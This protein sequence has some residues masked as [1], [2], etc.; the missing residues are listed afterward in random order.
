MTDS[1]R[2]GFDRGRR[3]DRSEF[4]MNLI[5]RSGSGLPSGGA[6]GLAG[7][8]ADGKRQLEEAEVG[9]LNEDDLD[10][11]QR[12]LKKKKGPKSSKM[13]ERDFAVKVQKKEKA[14]KAMEE[15]ALSAAVAAGGGASKDVQELV[16]EAAKVSF[17][18]SVKEDKTGTLKAGMF[19]NTH[20]ASVAKKAI[21]DAKAGKG[22]QEL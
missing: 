9:T 11:Y 21:K 4:S 6:D 2:N 16:V 19:S 14:Q 5:D 8:W 15:A 22:K 7:L 10:T 18:K 12:W 3:D 20:F 17:D 1:L 13:K